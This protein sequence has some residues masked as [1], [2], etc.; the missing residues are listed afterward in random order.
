MPLICINIICMYL[1]SVCEICIAIMVHMLKAIIYTY[2]YV[3]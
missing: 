2:V 1:L 3:Q